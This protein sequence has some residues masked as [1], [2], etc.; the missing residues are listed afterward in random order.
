MMGQS[1]KV[2][3][4]V[5]AATALMGAVAIGGAAPAQAPAKA[6]P[7]AAA[8]TSKAAGPAGGR[9]PGYNPDRNAYCYPDREP[10][11]D[12]DAG[13]RPAGCYTDADPGGRGPG[14]DAGT[15]GQHAKHRLRWSVLDGEWNVPRRDPVGHLA[16]D[17]RSCQREDRSPTPIRRS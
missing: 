4:R 16:H 9:L 13:R 10:N 6:P 2:V 14:R 1:R 12:A 5:A 11:P 3:A 15:K 7:R 8:A 17:P